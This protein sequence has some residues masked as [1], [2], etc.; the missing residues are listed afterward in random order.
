MA[1]D[2]VTWIQQE[3]NERGWS[4]SELARRGGFTPTAINKILS[5]ER[6]PGVDFCKGVARAFGMRDV[7]VM[8]IAG[9]ANSLPADDQPPGVREL[10]S[11]FM[12]LSDDD[13]DAV[14]KHVRALNEMQQAEKRHGMKLK[15]KPKPG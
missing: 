11:K 1:D 3:M 4:Q 2:F 15:R 6:M 5:R 9:I 12:L 14:L 8:R 13:Q 7:D 10:I